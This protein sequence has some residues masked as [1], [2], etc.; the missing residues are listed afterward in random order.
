MQFPKTIPNLINRL[1]AFLIGQLRAW[2]KPVTENALAQTVADVPRSR[3]A[4]LL[5]NAL[6]RQQLIVL[7]RQVK[8]PK[9][10]WR[11]R[12]VIVALASR[13]TTW[14]QTLLIVK[15]ETVLRWHRELFGR[16]WR[17]RSQPKPTLGRPRLP[18][19]QVDLIRQMAHANLTW[20]A[21]RIRGELLKLGWPVAKSTI[22]RYLKGRRA[23]GPGSQTWRTFLDNHAEAIWTCDFVQTHDLWLRDMFVFV[24]IELASQRVVHVAVTRHR[25]EVWVAQQLREATPFGEGPRYL[26]RDDDRKY[27][28]TFDRVAPGVGIDVIHTPIAARQFGVRTVP[29]QCASWVLLTNTVDK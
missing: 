1:S 5:E 27:D 3:Q 8:R 23:A 14:K 29:G 2:T 21:E 11:D 16:V 4:L 20:G 13:L 28:T 6:L 19:A 9:L 10:R 15:P 22:Q 17:R 12:A 26:S 7:K 25:G 24:I 18:K